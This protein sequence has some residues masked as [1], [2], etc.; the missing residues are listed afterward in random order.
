[1]AAGVVQQAQLGDDDICGMA[2]DTQDSE[3]IAGTVMAALD[4]RAAAAGLAG[5][6]ETVVA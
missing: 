1:M 5:E 4:A 6:F 2:N 3:M